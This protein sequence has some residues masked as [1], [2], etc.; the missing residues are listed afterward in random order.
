MNKQTN[1]NLIVVEGAEA[2]DQA[3]QEALTDFTVKT[4]QQNTKQ[5]RKEPPPI[6]PP[7]DQKVSPIPDSFL[8][9]HD[10]LPIAAILAW[11]RL[12]KMREMSEKDNNEMCEEDNKTEKCQAES[13]KTNTNQSHHQPKSFANFT[14]FSNHMTIFTSL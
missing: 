4:K 14:L 5:N 3:T 1:T 6:S 9:P 7:T 11:E 13:S 2:E 12:K 10:D 8:K